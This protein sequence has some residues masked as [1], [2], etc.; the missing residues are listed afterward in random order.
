MQSTRLS[1]VGDRV[2]TTYEPQFNS[3]SMAGRPRRPLGTPRGE[4]SRES[5][6][7][8]ASDSI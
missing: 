1:T 3:K 4:W 7:K 2:Y 5:P 6:E 8:A